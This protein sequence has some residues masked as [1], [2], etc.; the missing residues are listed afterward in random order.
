M[1]TTETYAQAIT[2]TAR[3]GRTH[4]ENGTYTT[5]IAA[6][7]IGQVY[8][9]ADAAGIARTTAM[10][11]FLEERSAPA[12]TAAD[13]YNLWFAHAYTAHGCCDGNGPDDVCSEGREL[14]EAFEVA[15]V[16]QA[17]ARISATQA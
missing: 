16:R 6:T 15:V 12:L 7:L 8:A 1:I 9:A 10:I 5:P 13:L 2:R 3:A 11:D 17:A 14:Y 4:I